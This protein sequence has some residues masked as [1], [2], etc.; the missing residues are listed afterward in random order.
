MQRLKEVKSWQ[1][2][3]GVREITPITIYGQIIVNHKLFNQLVNN[4]GTAQLH[5]N[6]T[7]DIIITR[8]RMI[9]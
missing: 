2:K 4:K 8:N 3:K 7:R 5:I 1:S 9:V 6:A